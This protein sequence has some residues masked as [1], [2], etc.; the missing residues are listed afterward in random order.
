MAFDP[1]GQTIWSMLVSAIGNEYGVAG[2]MGNL[3]A[4]SGLIPY[5][6][7]GD[8]TGYPYQPSLDYTNAVKNGTKSEYT[9]VHDSIG[10]GLAQWTS[11]SSVWSALV[12]AQDI[13]TASDVVLHDF[14]NPKDQ[15][16]AVEHA[17]WQYGVS[18][19]NAFSGSQPVPPTPP[20]PP[21]P[22]TPPSP[23]DKKHSMPLY[24]YP[25][26]NHQI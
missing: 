21:I 11:F 13:K 9:F 15:S 14:E 6:K 8:Y 18:I 1:Y 26:L 12:N 4:E 5:R 2:L 22:P 24:M 25:L 16:A 3:Y 7:Q 19:Y 10:Y 17:R 20:D 23:T